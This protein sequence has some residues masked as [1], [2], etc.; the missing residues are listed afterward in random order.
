MKSSSLPNTSKKLSGFLPSPQGRNPDKV[1][2]VLWEKQWPY[3]FIQKD[4]IICFR[5]LL[6]YG[7]QHLK[8]K[9][10]VFFI[11]T[12]FINKIS[13]GRNLFMEN[14]PSWHYCFRELNH[15]YLCLLIWSLEALIR[16]PMLLMLA[17]VSVVRFLGVATGADVSLACTVE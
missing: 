7:K 3:K 9:F 5:D 13:K 17:N 14:I 6:T 12:F 4:I 16:L 1:L 11:S 2:L 15:I 8:L 10:F